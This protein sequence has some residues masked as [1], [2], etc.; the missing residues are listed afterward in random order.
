M[1]KFKQRVPNWADS[2]PLCV[3][4]ENVGALL[5]HEYILKYITPKFV[6]FSQTIE[7]NQT[8]TGMPPEWND[9]VS[10]YESQLHSVIGKAARFAETW[11]GK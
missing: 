5:S 6:R 11:R 1:L 7:Y 9:E 2:E 10:W 8:S 3:E 4:A